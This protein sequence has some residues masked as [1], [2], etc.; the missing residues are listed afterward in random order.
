MIPSAT[1]FVNISQYDA[2]KSN[3]EINIEYVV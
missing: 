2:D 3:L 1:E